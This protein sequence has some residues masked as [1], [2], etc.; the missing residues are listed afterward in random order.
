MVTYDSLCVYWRWPGCLQRYQVLFVIFGAFLIHLSLGSIY[1]IG[2]MIPYIVSFVR[3]SSEPQ[4]LRSSDATYL[5]ACQTTGHGVMIILGGLMEK[6]IGPRLAT[7]IGC[8]LMCAGVLL[9]YFTIQISFWLVLI[10]YG[11]MF[12]FGLGIAYIGPITC[13]MKWLPKWKA[14]AAGIVV[15]GYGLSSTIFNALQ[16]AYINPHNVQPDAQPFPENPK[17]KY[18]TDH[19]LL[20]RVPYV[21]L[22]LGLVYGMIQLIGCVF[23]V[24]PPPHEEYSINLLNNEDK[25]LCLCDQR[26]RTGPFPRS[27]SVS[28][29]KFDSDQSTE[30][31]SLLGSINSTKSTN[32]NKLVVSWSRNV[33][34]N[35]TPK[36][37]LTKLNFYIQWLMFMIAGLSVNFVSSLYKQFGLENEVDDHFLAAVGS[38]AAFFNLLGRILWGLLADVVTY[39]FALVLQVGVMTCLLLTLYITTVGGKWMFM[40]WVCGLFFCIGGNYSIFP[41]AIARSFGQLHLGVNYGLLFTSQTVGALLSAF[42]ASTLVHVIDWWGVLFLLGGLSILELLFALCYRHK[43]YV[44]LEKPDMLHSAASRSNSISVKFPDL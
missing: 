44:L 23:L 28:D 10:T 9:T 33:V 30:S 37:M 38:V 19:D 1:S 39:K 27:N 41:A 43:R 2:N 17:E 21:F 12:G 11:L 4:T 42:L 25:N 35:V 16:T 31:S 18:F 22:I 26:V 3:N 15:A 40:I 34:L 29:T 13:I 36:A 20:Q 24:N 5:A 14:V 7:L 6:R 8:C 32:S